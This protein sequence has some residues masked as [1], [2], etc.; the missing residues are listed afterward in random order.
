MSGSVNK[1]NLV[2][3]NVWKH[4]N[5]NLS[6]SSN[7]RP[8]TGAPGLGRLYADA[9]GV[10]VDVPEG[11]ERAT[12]E[13]AGVVGRGEEMGILGV[14]ERVMAWT[15]CTTVAVSNCFQKV[16]LPWHGGN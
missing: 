4:V 6:V 1:R 15:L 7:S 13:E 2:P 16:I 5:R 12:F 11:D 14:M 9:A 3:V 8:V 10:G